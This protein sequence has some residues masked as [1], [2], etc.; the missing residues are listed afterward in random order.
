MVR[1]IQS[2]AIETAINTENREHNCMKTYRKRRVRVEHGE[3]GDDRCPA[4][5]WQVG[6]VICQS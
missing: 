3:C 6:S 1:H 2:Y 4:L 5:L